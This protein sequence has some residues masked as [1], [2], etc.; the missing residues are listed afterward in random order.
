MGRLEGR[1]N[2]LDFMGL[3]LSVPNESI[4]LPE[5]EIPFDLVILPELNQ[6]ISLGIGLAVWDIATKTLVHYIHCDNLKVSWDIWETNCFCASRQHNQVAIGFYGYYGK[7]GYKICLFDAT[8]WS[9]PKWFM[10][11]ELYP[12]SVALSSDGK[13]LAATLSDNQSARV[14]DTENGML[15]GECSA[16]KMTTVLF[17]P[18]NQYLITGANVPDALSLWAL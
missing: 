13:W 10:S 8:S 11:D 17:S 14:W 15:V 4:P 16:D 6:L 18:D 7:A 5:Y 9:N 3:S 1:T 2:Y 12:N